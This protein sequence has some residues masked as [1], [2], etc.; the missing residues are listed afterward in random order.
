VTAAELFAKGGL[1]MYCIS[2]LSIYGMGV[3]FYKIY[4]FAT[5]GIFDNTFVELALREV[6]A[7]DI[8]RAN[9]ILSA[10]KGPV[11]RIMRVSLECVANRE[12]SQK[13]REG[14]ISRI[15]TADL[16]YLESH[17]RGLEMVASVGPLL[18]LLGTVTGMISAFARLE[19][20]GT[21]VDPSM[22]AGGIW[23]ALLTTVFGLVVAVPAVVAYYIFDAIIEKVR[24][25]MKD[26][27]TQVLALE[28]EFRRNEREVQ[29]RDLLKREIEKREPGTVD[30]RREQAAGAAA[31]RTAPQ[32][33]NTLRLL[34]PRYTL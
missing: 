1:V 5:S 18:G 2:I 19:S 14:E 23:E 8:A 26:A 15:G 4:Q 28:D 10:A 25:Q 30:R 17:L 13:S 32:S 9:R 27:S 11:A 22:L 3:I 21:R 16:R 34:N 33:S 24:L 29:R 6:K 31:P 12:I 7:G 20:A